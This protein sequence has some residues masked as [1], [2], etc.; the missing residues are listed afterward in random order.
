M[1]YGVPMK[2]CVPLKR[3]GRCKQ[4]KPLR[5]FAKRRASRDGL[6]AHCRECDW[7]GR[8]GKTAGRFAISGDVEEATERNLRE[9]FARQERTARKVT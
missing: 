2:K 3:C 8:T 5:D 6:Q 9:A 7:K 4:E 1:V